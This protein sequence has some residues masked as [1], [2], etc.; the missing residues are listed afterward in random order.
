MAKWNWKSVKKKD[1]EYWDYWREI[2]DE[3][4]QPFN[5]FCFVEMNKEDGWFTIWQGKEIDAQNVTVY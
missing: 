4:G 2:K 1:V 5:E 3:A